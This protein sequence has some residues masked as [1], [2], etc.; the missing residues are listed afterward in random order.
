MI[1]VTKRNG[2]MEALNLDKIHQI[3]FFACEGLTGV[4]VSEIEIRAQLQFYEGIQTSLIH[5]ILIKSAS[6][7]ITVDNPN[8]Q[9]VAGRLVNYSLRKQVYGDY[10]P[11]KFS[12]HVQDLVDKGI[13]D[14]E[15]LEKYTLQEIEELGKYIKHKRDEKFTYV[16]M[17]Q[18]EGKYLCKNRVTKQIWE[19]PQMAYMLMSAIIFM[20]YGSDRMA[21]VKRFYDAISNFDISLPTPIMAGLRTNTRQFSSCVVLNVGDSLDSIGASNHA[22][23]RYISRKAGLGINFGRV[24]AIDSAIRGGDAVHTG[25]IPFI[26]AAAKTVKSCSQGGVR[27][28]AATIHF[29][30]WHYEFESL[31][32]LKNNKGTEFNRVR[33]MDYCFQMNKTMYTRL[34]QRKDI[35]FFSPSDV[36]G[37]YEAFC[38]DQKEFERLYTKYEADPSIRRKTIPAV[39]VFTTL[40]NE[41]ASTGRIYIQNIDLTNEHS[42][43]DPAV[44][45]IEQ[46]NLCQEIALPSVTF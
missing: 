18:W 10:E 27:G 20:E 37:L 6:E 44:A 13:Y 16:A 12:A 34:V 30:L 35:S 36:P 32:V 40:M 21:Y 24:R 3:L 29:P 39:D 2:A 25:V 17:K 26:A 11:I 8:Y 43:F 7:L 23:L 38:A 28:G 33:Q 19:T 22:I 14:P 9:Y 4:S 46:S 41:R 31:V 5:D 42:P 45:P 15:V 1:N